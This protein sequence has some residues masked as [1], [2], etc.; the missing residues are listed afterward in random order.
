MVKQLLFSC[1]QCGTNFGKWSGQCDNCKAWNTIV[2]EIPL[3]SGPRNSSIGSARGEIIKFSKLSATDKTPERTLSGVKELDRVLGGGLV[4]SSAILVGGDP[5][6]GKSTLLL[7]AAARFSRLGLDVLYISGEEAVD[8][9]RLRA[10]RLKLQESPLKLAAETNLRN[11]LTTLDSLK[12]NLAIIDSI[13]TIWSD[14]LDSAPGSVS[15]VRVASH[16]LITFAKTRNTSI[17][18]VG[19][20]T[21]DG[22]LAGPR[23]VEHMVD[24]VLYFEGERSHNFRILRAVKNRF[25]ATDEIGVFE[26]TGAGLIEVQNPSAMFIGDRDKSTPGSA[27]FAGIEGTRTVL[28]EIQALVSPSPHSQ[29]RRT[30]VGID[31]GRLATILAVLEAHCKI[32]FSNYDVYLNVA[33]GLRVSE[34]AADLAI[35]AAILSSKQ[36]IVL[37]LNTI[38]FGEISLSGS[39]RPV[40]QV[41]NRI[42]EAKK[43]GF[44]GAIISK[45]KKKVEQSLIETT[46][47]EDINAF[48]N[49]LSLK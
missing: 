19:H 17:V 12:P 38:I 10:K 7:Q 32:Q 36:G 45:G 28:S 26:M 15:Q 30:V 31:G 27:I 4:D 35:A 49:K 37:P 8:Q 44:K 34:P 2:Q 3:S 16:E 33:G 20:V 14:N 29:A 22:Q 39:L 1:S 6:I 46:E 42:R 21:K 24:T 48:I 18:L 9:I 23:V 13:Q 43:L 25:G 40:S 11:I 5:G 41:E 47:F